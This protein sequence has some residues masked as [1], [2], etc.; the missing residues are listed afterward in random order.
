M[1]AKSKVS[2]CCITFYVSAGIVFPLFFKDTAISICRQ[3]IEKYLIEH[4]EI[5]PENL[6]DFFNNPIPVFVSLKKGNQTR[7]CSGSFKT[8]TGTLAGDLIKFSIISVAGDYRYRPVSLSEMKDIRIQ[9]TIP[10]SPVE[11]P[12][13]FFYN[14]E[15][16]GL[17][18]EKQGKQ[19]LVLPREAKTAEYAF[20][21]CLRNAGINDTSGITIFKFSAIIFTEDEK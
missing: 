18:I 2:R 5:I 9:I 6:P 1:I 3:A 17:I 12:S 15:K 11:I 21:M 13:L 16:E 8:E 10:D 7:G 20:K 14:P 4:I 19:G